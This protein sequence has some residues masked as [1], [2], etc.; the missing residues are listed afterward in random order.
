MRDGCMSS[1]SCRVSRSCPAIGPPSLRSYCWLACDRDERQP[2]GQLNTVED[3]EGRHHLI[4]Q[5]GAA[6]PPQSEQANIDQPSE[7]ADRVT[8]PNPLDDKAAHLE[9]AAPLRFG[10][11]AALAN[12][13]AGGP[14][15]CR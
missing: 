12:A 9:F 1:P 14:Q 15:D 4:E 13:L 8:S 3:R 7:R 5:V 6:Q 11:A 2:N 10:V